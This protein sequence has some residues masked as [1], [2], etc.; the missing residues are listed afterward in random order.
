MHSHLEPVAVNLSD[1]MHVSTNRLHCIVHH[2]WSA[3]VNPGHLY[4]EAAA[5]LCECVH[6]VCVCMC[7]RVCVRACMRTCMRACGCM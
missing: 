6:G 3:G 2:A 5:S 7:V 1:P 4:Y